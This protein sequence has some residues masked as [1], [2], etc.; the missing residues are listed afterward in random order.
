MNDQRPVAQRR[1]LLRRRAR[2]G[3]TR[4]DQQTVKHGP[5]HERVTRLDWINRRRA[6]KAIAV[7]AR[8]DEI[9]QKYLSKSCGE[10]RREVAHLVGMGEDDQLRL[11][12]RHLPD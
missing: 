9:R 7:Q 3:E 10:T 8:A 5:H 4:I 6:R 12:L 2:S 1:R 11:L